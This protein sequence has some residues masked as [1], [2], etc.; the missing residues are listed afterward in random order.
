MNCKAVVIPSITGTYTFPHVEAFYFEKIV[1]SYKDNLDKIF[2]DKIMEINIDDFKSLENKYSEFL[3]NKDD[4]INKMIKSNKKFYQEN[5]SVLS[6][7][8][9]YKK[10]IDQY[11]SDINK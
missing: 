1:F 7:T 10:V 9:I 8:K 2:H 6:N 4:Q 3:E 5:I 11:L